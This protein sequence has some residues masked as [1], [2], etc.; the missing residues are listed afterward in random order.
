M[1]QIPMSMSIDEIE[2]ACHE[3]TEINKAEFSD[4]DEYRLMI[5][6]TGGLL[7]R[8]EEVGALGTNV[9]I[10][11]FPLRWATRGM[12]KLFEE[13]LQLRIPSQRQIPA[14]YLDPK[15]KHRSRLHLKMAL[16][17]CEWPLL[18]DDQGFITEGPGYNFFIIKD[19]MVNT[20]EPRNILRGIS[21][22]YIYELYDFVE[23]NIEPYDVYD[24]DGAFITATPFCMLPVASLNGV[25][26]PRSPIF[27]EILAS[28]NNLVGTDIKVQIQKWDEGR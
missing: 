3:I 25:S 15:I 22:E 21:R 18:V 24:S 17:E 4:D 11:I 12:G 8:Y 27:D 19:G 10:S 5:D 14:Q 20:P 9:I 28:W 6:V 23:L 2:K 7:P 26:I 13:G 1:V 16:N